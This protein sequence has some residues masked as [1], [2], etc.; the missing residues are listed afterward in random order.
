[1]IDG[2][3]MKIAVM[4]VAGLVMIF[5]AGLGGAGVAGAVGAGLG[6]ARVAPAGLSPQAAGSGFAF[7]VPPTSAHKKLVFAHYWPPEPISLDNGQPSSDYFTRYLDPRGEDG[8][9]FDVG[10]LQRNRP[11]PRN[12]ST[13]TSW[14]QLS[15]P[16]WMA[17]GGNGAAVPQWVFDDARTEVQQAQTAGIDG[18][19]LNLFDLTD[20]SIDNG[21]RELAMLKVASTVPGFKVMLQPDTSVIY[22]SDRK[23]VACGSIQSQYEGAANSQRCWP[24]AAHMAANLK[25]FIDLGGNAIYRSTSGPSAGKIVLSPFVADDGCRQKVDAACTAARAGATYWSSVLSQLHGYGASY[26]AVLSPVFVYPWAG[27]ISAYAPIS[28]GAGWWGVRDPVVIAQTPAIGKTVKAITGY[29]SAKLSWMQAVAVQDARPKSGVY[30]EAANSGALRASWERATTGQV[31]SWVGSKV[32]RV[33]DAPADVVLLTTWNDHTET[34][35]FEPTVQ[36]GWSVLGI[37]AY[38][39]S[40]YQTGVFPKVTRD[41]IYVS[42]RVQ[43]LG[44]QPKL[45]NATYTDSAGTVHTYNIFQSY[46]GSPN[47]KATGDG[48]AGRNT[49]EVLTMLTVKRTVKVV[50]GSKSYSYTAPAG[51]SVASYPLQVGSVKA[52][53]LQGTKVIGVADTGKKVGTPQTEDLGYYFAGSL[54]AP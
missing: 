5:T 35:A 54:Q 30:Y 20:L 8:K 40:N 39:Q 16:S 19:A 23:G 47:G 51:V 33:Q 18:F 41:A 4:L 26:D 12:S 28:V 49:V 50:V 15:L 25:T 27:L 46:N 43:L 44:A 17:N 48:L 14:V 29:G 32:D 10:G 52:S 24:S 34:T 11:I 7:A 42:H 22:G 21:P 45:A 2:R 38:Y 9:H 3:R 1:M 31:G 53:L 13:A 37:N 6:T 36:T